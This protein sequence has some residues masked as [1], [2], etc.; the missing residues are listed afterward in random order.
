M[1]RFPKGKTKTELKDDALFF[2][3]L[4]NC[5]NSLAVDGPDAGSGNPKGHPTVFLW[6]KKPLLLDIYPEFAFRL[7]IGMGNVIP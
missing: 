7:V 4:Q 5:A 2:Q 3:F 6:N 1:F